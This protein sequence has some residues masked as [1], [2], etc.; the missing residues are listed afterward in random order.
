MRNYA[1]TGKLEISNAAGCS[2]PCSS[3]GAMVNNSITFAAVPDLKAQIASYLADIKSG[4][5][6]TLPAGG[7]TLIAIWVGECSFF[8]FSFGLYSCR[9]VNQ[10]ST[11]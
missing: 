11:Q 8:P 4:L 2:N 3:A 9:P 1:Y 7:K 6:P 5:I 10:V